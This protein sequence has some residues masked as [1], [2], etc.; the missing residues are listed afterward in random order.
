VTLASRKVRSRSPGPF[1]MTGADRWIATLHTLELWSRRHPLTF[2][3]TVVTW[4]GFMTTL[5]VSSPAID[6]RDIPRSL[7]RFWAWQLWRRVWNRPVVVRMADGSS[8][9]LPP[10]NKLASMI[11]AVGMH[12]PR[13]ELFSAR[14]IRR[15]DIVVD[16]G[17][18]IG[19]YTTMAAARGAQVFAFEPSTQARAVLTHNVARNDGGPVEVIAAAL[20]N[21][22]GIMRLT[23]GLDIQNH[24]GAMDVDGPSEMVAVCLLD[25][26]TIGARPKIAGPV[27]L[28]KIDAEGYDHA[29]LEGAEATIARDHPVMIIETWGRE[30]TRSWLEARGYGI[31]LYHFE[32]AALLEYPSPWTRQANLIAIHRDDLPAVT[33]RLD[34]STVTRPGLPQLVWW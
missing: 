29:V 13:E 20:S 34:R 16:V 27:V 1:E 17:A 26:F 6:R 23:T 31:Y 33:E 21:E 30:H 11:V 3:L 10:W 2:P 5:I 8:M 22:S 19:I 4:S 7:F 24:L 28:M 12:E 9:T 25:E 18:N 15:G 32:S 14:F